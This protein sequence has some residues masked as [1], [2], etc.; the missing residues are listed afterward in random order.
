MLN[1][2]NRKVL[3]KE[4]TIMSNKQIRVACLGPLES[5]SYI[6]A[7]NYFGDESEYIFMSQSDACRSVRLGKADYA[8]L[9]V[10]NNTG[11]FVDTTLDALHW[12]GEVV[13]RDQIYLAVKQH[14]I[15][16]ASNITDIEVIY[17]HPQAFLQCRHSLKKLKSHCGHPIREIHVESTSAGVEMAGNDPRSAAIGSAEAAARYH[18]PLLRKDF[19][20]NRKNTTR[21][22]VVGMGKI[23]EPTDQDRSAF[24]FEVHHQPGA[25]ATVFA[26]FKDA[27]INLLSLQSRPVNHVETTNWDYSFFLECEGHIYNEPLQTLYKVL[28]T[29]RPKTLRRKVRCL[30]SFP[31]R[32]QK[33][34]AHFP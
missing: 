20:H 1:A 19:H 23:E 3:L 12:T 5:F 24:L 31:D 32:L 2:P 6:A 15:S 16:M 7:K 29:G 9:P 4:E 27:R 17:S 34:W 11:G 30:G 8:V 21:F 22:F 13:I 25:L 33:H 18:V 10:E 26:Q 28:R 14:L